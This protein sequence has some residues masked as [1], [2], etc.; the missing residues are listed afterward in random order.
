MLPASTLDAAVFF[1]DDGTAY[2][3]RVNEVPA[4]SGYG[5]PITKFFKMADQ[6]KVIAA[7]TSDPRFTPADRPDGT[8][9]VAVALTNGYV[10]RIPLAAYRVESSKSGRKFARPEPG[11]KV[12]MAR[13]V[14]GES[15]MMLASR[16]GHVIH[17][18]LD[19]ANVL[20][21]VGKGVI[22]IKLD[23]GDQCIGGTL[24]S[25]GRR[26]EQNRITLEMDNGKPDDYPPEKI[27][28]QARGG[29]G[30]KVRH[31]VEFVR[32]TPPPIE[33]VNWDEVEGRPERKPKDAERNGHAE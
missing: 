16:G 3:M 14:G 27:K 33:L 15:G 31:R 4:S 10:F 20:A 13:L 25:D 22:G 23:A 2:T 5:E 30:E 6:V 19:E 24:V 17:F 29:K 1:T 7:F 12:V 18:A 21:G 11:D 9:H 26:N 8:P 32:V 28:P